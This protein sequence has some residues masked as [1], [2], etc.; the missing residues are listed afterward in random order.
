MLLLVSDLGMWLKHHL[1]GEE[2]RQSSRKK[3]FNQEQ[4]VQ[5]QNQL[6][7]ES[8]S[9][10]WLQCLLWAAFPPGFLQKDTSDVP[11]DALGMNNT[12]EVTVHGQSEWGILQDG[13]TLIHGHRKVIKPPTRGLVLQG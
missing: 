8:L 3:D 6:P 9:C 11:M 10:L 1:Q 4:T 12:R 5:H 2:R 7:R 13:Q